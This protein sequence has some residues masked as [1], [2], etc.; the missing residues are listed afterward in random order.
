MDGAS[1]FFAVDPESV[2][3]ASS[4]S[5]VVLEDGCAGVGQILVC[6]AGEGEVVLVSTAGGSSCWGCSSR[7][8]QD[9]E[10]RYR[11]RMDCRWKVV[12]RDG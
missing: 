10:N 5:Y 9:C 11:S 1:R 8:V 7:T 2:A 3:R 12:D 6:Y 4:R